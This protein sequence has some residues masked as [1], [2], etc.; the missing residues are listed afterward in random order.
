MQ[1]SLRLPLSLAGAAALALS[2]TP[3]QPVAAQEEDGSAA[4]LGVMEINLKD[5]VQHKWRFEGALQGAGTPNLVGL[6]FFS[7]IAK[8]EKSFLY[9]DGIVNANFSDRDMDSSIVETTVK[10]TTISTSTR[11]GYRWLNSDKR[12]IYGVNAGYDSRPIATGYMTNG[13]ALLDSELTAFF[14]QLAVGLEAKSSN[15]LMDAYALVPIGETEQWLNWYAA[16]GALNTYGL[17]IGIVIDDKTSVYAGYYYQEGDLG[18]GNSSGVRGK[19]RYELNDYLS[20]SLKASYDKAFDARISANIILK[21]TPNQGSPKFNTSPLNALLEQSPG[22]RQVRVHDCHW[23]DPECDIHVIES[24]GKHAVN[25]VHHHVVQPV[26]N[27]VKSDTE[28]TKQWLKRETGLS[29]EEIDRA[30]HVLGKSIKKGVTEKVAQKI[31]KK[32]AQKIYKWADNVE[33][34]NEAFKEMTAQLREF[35]EK[36]VEDEYYY[37]SDAID[38][39]ILEDP[40]L[41]LEALG[42]ASAIAAE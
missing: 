14:Q 32:I 1:R 25:W 21:F 12:W 7:P 42:E 3:I 37:G 29:M 24:G 20:T 4:D 31:M 33:E 18:A 16:G 35:A 8:T 5:A 36:A 34:D 19:L 28:S 26:I 2:S 39:L 22:N 38:E 30:F 11:I 10:G 13:I 23:Y 41:T 40:E 9:I 27:G 6:G 15:Y 17:D